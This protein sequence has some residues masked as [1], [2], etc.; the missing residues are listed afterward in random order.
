MTV[1]ITL[2]AL[3]L[4]AIILG[5]CSLTGGSIQGSSSVQVK[6]TA[7]PPGVAGAG[8]PALTTTIPLAAQES[9]TFGT[10][11]GQINII[12]SQARTLAASSN[13]TLDIN[14]GLADIFNAT[15]TMLHLKYIYLAIQSGGD[16][17]GLTLAGGASNPFLGPLAGTTPT[18]TVYPNGPGYQNGEPTVGWTVSSGAAN[19]KITNNSSSASVTYQIVLGGTTT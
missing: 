2:F 3:L 18:L 15:P 7:A 14:T 9:L 19:I 11:T 17:T 1:A 10:S 16:V 5:P 13:E 4:I 8:V 12:I 6:G